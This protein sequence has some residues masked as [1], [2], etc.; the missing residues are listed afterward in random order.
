MD[1]DGHD[2]RI[3][4]AD[5]RFGWIALGGVTLF[6]MLLCL[7]AL[8]DITTDNATQFP[9]EYSLLV[10]GGAWLLFIAWSLWQSG[11]RLNAILTVASLAVAALLAAGGIGHKRDGGWSVFWPQYL[12]LTWAWVHGVVVGI[13]LIRRSLK[14]PAKAGSHD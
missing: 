6:A 5:A 4:G 1:A 9:V 12:A 11:S 10:L 2:S 3:A 8:D 7:L 13:L 14:E